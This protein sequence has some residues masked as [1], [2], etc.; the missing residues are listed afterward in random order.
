MAIF[1]PAT[2][3][4]SDSGFNPQNPQC[5]PAVNPAKAGRLP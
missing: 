5:I 3:G 1:R 4:T 2:G